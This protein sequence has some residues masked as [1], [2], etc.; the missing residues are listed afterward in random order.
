[1]LKRTGLSFGEIDML[2]MELDGDFGAF[3]ARLRAVADA[4]DIPD[5]LLDDAAVSPLPER[6]AGR[7]WAK[8][9]ILFISDISGMKY[10]F[11]WELSQFVSKAKYRQPEIS[12]TALGNVLGPDL[13][14][15]ILVVARHPVQQAVYFRVERPAA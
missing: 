10:R 14:R 1:M 3:D 13:E 4:P 7:K 12:D 6:T 8:T 5:D 9:P 11:R 15:Q 2:T